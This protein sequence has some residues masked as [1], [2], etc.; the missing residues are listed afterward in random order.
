MTCLLQPFTYFFFLAA[1][2][3]E[4]EDLNYYYANYSR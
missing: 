2:S 4:M 1:E 3:I